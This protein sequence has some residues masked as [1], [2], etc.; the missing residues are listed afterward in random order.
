M[1]FCCGF[2]SESLDKLMFDKICTMKIYRTLDVMTLQEIFTNLNNYKPDDEYLNKI[3]NISERAKKNFEN[4]HKQ[5]LK[6]KYLMICKNY[7]YVYDPDNKHL[8]FHENLVEKVFEISN[9]RREKIILL[10]YSF[11]NNPKKK[12][13]L[14]ELFFINS[15][16]A[17]R[18]KESS[19]IKY[20]D[21]KSLLCEYVHK[22]LYCSFTALGFSHSEESEIFEKIMHIIN[23]KLNK[24]NIESFQDAI[25][26]NFE[27]EKL[28]E[29]HPSIIKRKLSA[30]GLLNR[31]KFFEK[32]TI[33]KEEIDKIFEENGY[34]HNVC[35]LVAKY[36]SYFS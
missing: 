14:S 17:D 32:I 4:S 15:Q 19:D 29:T 26:K 31:E 10:F 7:I 18:E 3:S 8:K 6:E 22:I 20:L 28:K 30:S 25:L 11:I 33:N 23:D 34:L 24:E 5:I 9:C 21:F 36:I 1:D 12:P 16:Q 2:K 27:E 13:Y 35:E